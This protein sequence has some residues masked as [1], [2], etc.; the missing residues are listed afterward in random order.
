[1]APEPAAGRQGNG[2]SLVSPSTSRSGAHRGEDLLQAVNEMKITFSRVESGLTLWNDR[3][4]IASHGDGSV[5][6]LLPVPQVHRRA[7][8]LEA[9]SPRPGVESHLPRAPVA[10]AAE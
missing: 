4:Q 7:D 3:R 5:G 8:V 1:M 6:V 2:G 10:P 9:K